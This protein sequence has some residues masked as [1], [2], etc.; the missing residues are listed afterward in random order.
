M[1]MAPGELARLVA[2]ALQ[3]HGAPLGVA[4]LAAEMVVMGQSFAEPAVELALEHCARG[5]L[6]AGPAAWVDA[7]DAAGDCM[8]GHGSSALLWAADAGD[9]AAARAADPTCALAQVVVR[10]VLTPALAAPGLLRCARLGLLALMAWAEETDGS[11]RR[12]WSAAGPGPEGPWL[13]TVPQ[14][15]P[16]AMVLARLGGAGLSEPAPG[17]FMLWCG[18]L[19]GGGETKALFD[20]AGRAEGAAGTVVLDSRGLHEH[21]LQ[22]QRSGVA[23]DVAVLGRLTAAGAAV[24]VP[25]EH[26]HRVLDPGFD[27]LKAF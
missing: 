18:Q 1:R 13:V 10:D 11:T 9:L 5:A 21:I 14:G 16:P 23:I 17:S 24:L 19:Q 4:E 12:G 26:E 20:A 2:A 15:D 8:L 3:G 7:G 22:A 25:H 6:Q 27:P